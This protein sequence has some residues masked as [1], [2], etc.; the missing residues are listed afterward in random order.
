MVPSVLAN[1]AINSSFNQERCGLVEQRDNND[2]D[3]G[4]EVVFLQTPGVTDDF[5]DV[6]QIVSFYILVRRQRGP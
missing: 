3:D 6:F 5:G 2:E 1:D 4:Y